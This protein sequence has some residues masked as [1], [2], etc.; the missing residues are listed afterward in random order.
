MV[1]IGCQKAVPPL[2]DTTDRPHD[3]AVEVVVT[4]PDGELLQQRSGAGGVTVKVEAFGRD[5]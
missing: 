5:G 4:V 2:K 3:R 1:I